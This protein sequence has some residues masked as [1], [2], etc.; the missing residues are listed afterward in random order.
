M[1]V[2]TIIRLALSMALLAVTAVPL[3]AT[4]A[5]AQPA[6]PA[7]SIS[8]RVT[9]PAGRAIPQYVIQYFPAP[10][11]AKRDSV[12]T[13]QQGR[14]TIQNLPPGAYF[15][16]MFNPSDVPANVRGAME[17]LPGASPEMAR[18]GAPLTRR[19]SVG[20]GQT[21]TGIDFVVIPQT[22]RPKV[23]SPH[24]GPGG[25]N[26][27]APGTGTGDAAAGRRPPVWLWLLA[28]G[29]AALA[30]GLMPFL[31]PRRSAK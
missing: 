23:E 19:V 12:A 27:G 22:G 9:D 26:I 30:G 14:Y 10:D 4:V 6:P 3:T 2:R 8:G 31:W 5:S 25:L 21:V 24:G 7:G 20:A 15:V 28:A 1:K 11:A 17:N 13:D 18:L 29:G 16:G